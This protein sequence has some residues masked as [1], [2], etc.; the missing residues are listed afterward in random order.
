MRSL[1]KNKTILVTGSGRGI[2]AA[3]AV[4][5]AEEG[6]RVVVNYLQD[7]VAAETTVSAIRNSGGK[8]I[9]IQAN[10][11]DP[12]QTESLVSQTVRTFGTLDVLI[13]NAHTPFEQTSFE[14]LTWEQIDEQISG[15]L[16]SAFHCS[17]FTLPHLKR[18]PSSSILNVS[19]VTVRLPEV[20][21]SHRNIAKAALEEL[22]RC[23]A[24]ELADTG[25][26]VNGLS[27]GWTDT[28]QTKS[29]SADYIQRKTSEIPMK[30][31]ARP[32]EIADAAI[33]LI[34]P[35]STYITGT[36]LPV[37]GGL[38]PDIE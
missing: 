15:T 3:I 4:R 14:N 6:A 37:A 19:S 13:N 10:V 28:D 32:E 31:F 33:F 16:R 22:T 5:C 2:G 23:L 1:L 27:V 7:K 21:F 17:Q 12:L 11:R 30:R 8:G 35:L 36:V 9:A 38:R 20:G 29:F 24:V 26:R 18:G 25:I 34:S